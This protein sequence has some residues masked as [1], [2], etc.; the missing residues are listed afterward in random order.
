M[1]AYFEDARVIVEID[2]HDVHSGPVSFE[3][4]RDRD[5]D[6][7]ALDLPTIRVTEERLDNA[8]AREA[9]RLHKILA[10]RAA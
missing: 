3:G 10:R 6:M 5:A 4:D 8:P 1:D 2:G 9:E 7:L